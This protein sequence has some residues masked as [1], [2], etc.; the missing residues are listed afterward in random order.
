MAN[1]TKV[2]TVGL[3]ERLQQHMTDIRALH[4]RERLKKGAELLAQMLE[5]SE[6]FSVYYLE[7]RGLLSLNVKLELPAKE[8][9]KERK[10]DKCA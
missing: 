8:K 1:Y 9:E 2:L 10:I 4:G 7:V 3:T 5:V 6:I